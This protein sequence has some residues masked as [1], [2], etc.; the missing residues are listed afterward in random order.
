MFLSLEV[1]IP[2]GG[3]ARNRALF[4]IAGIEREKLGKATRMLVFADLALCSHVVAV[5]RRRG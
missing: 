3:H 2:K 5:T 4:I 1:R